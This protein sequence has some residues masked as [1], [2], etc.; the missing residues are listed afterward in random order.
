MP[1]RSKT[2]KKGLRWNE[3]VKRWVIDYRW[4][5][6]PEMTM[7]R[8]HERLPR[9]TTATAARARYESVVRAALGGSLVT[10]RKAPR[11]LHAALDEYIAWC[12]T[13]R[14]RTLPDRR[15]LVRAVKRHMADIALKEVSA[16][17]VEK[18]KRDRRAD[19]VAPATVNRAVA[20]FKDFTGLGARWGWVGDAAAAGVRSVK[21]LKEPPGRVRWLT[22]DEARRLLAALRPDVRQIAATAMLTGMRLGELVGLKKSEVDLDHLVIKLTRTKTNRARQVPINTALAAI[23][24]AAIKASP[25]TASTSS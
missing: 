8:H 20:M 2:G 12:E 24:E 15:S 5:A 4:R 14:P 1:R 13:N 22:S 19:E 21:L 25:R 7:K 16:F 3:K 6:V 11:R 17:L 9:G 23:L 18:L 10:D